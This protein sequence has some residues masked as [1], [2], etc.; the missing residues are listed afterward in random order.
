MAE[1]VLANFS[2]MLDSM[3]FA[4]EL[5]L[6]GI[7]NFHFRQRKKA[8]RELRAMSIGLWR[9]GLERSFPSDGEALFERFMLTLYERA[10]S[11]KERERA[12]AFDLLTRSYI[13]RFRE[14]GDADFTPVSG[15]IVSLFRNEPALAAAR[16]LKLALL[17]RDAYITIFRHLI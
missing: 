14:R 9:L 10:H 17:I 15:Y 16:R 8:V 5:A 1:A 13:D 11:A 2:A 7:R 3:D 4:Q 6:L 12:N